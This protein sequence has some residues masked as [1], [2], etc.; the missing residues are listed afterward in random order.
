M[1]HLQ[2]LITELEQERDT[3]CN[4]AEEL[5]EKDNSQMADR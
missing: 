5:V 2:L 1:E 4:I 3:F